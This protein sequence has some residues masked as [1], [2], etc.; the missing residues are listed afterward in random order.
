MKSVL[1]GTDGNDILVEMDPL[2]IPLI[3][4]P[5]SDEELTDF[6]AACLAHGRELCFYCNTCAIPTCNKC[7]LTKHKDHN[8][9]D[10]EEKVRDVNIYYNLD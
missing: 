10:I 1:E 9:T 6:S 4:Y 5:F 2:V 8:V 7:F 3:F